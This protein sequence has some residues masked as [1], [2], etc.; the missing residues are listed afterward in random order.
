MAMDTAS[1]ASEPGVDTALPTAA[2]YCRE[3]SEPAH[4]TIRDNTCQGWWRF[5]HLLFPGAE[6]VSSYQCLLKGG[7]DE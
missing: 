6:L 7:I 2:D 1:Q 5:H 4:S 3:Y